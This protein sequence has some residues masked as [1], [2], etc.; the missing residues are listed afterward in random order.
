MANARREQPQLVSAMLEP[1]FYPH[2]PESVELRETH[3]SW[4]FLAGDLAYKVKKPLTLPFLNY[5]SPERRR[6]M[7][8]RRCA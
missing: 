3:I 7:C 6:E 1:G 5:G 2:A 8:R 4:V